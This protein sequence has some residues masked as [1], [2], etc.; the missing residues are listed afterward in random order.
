MTRLLIVL[1]L[2]PSLAFAIERTITI[3]P[4][5]DMSKATHFEIWGN[6]EGETDKRH[7]LDVTVDS[8]QFKLEVDECKF[9]YIQAKTCNPIDCTESGA[10]ELVAPKCIQADP[11]ILDGVK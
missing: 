5:G 11:P 8:L 3:T 2:F 6:Y 4:Q 1:I 9:F 10:I 7:L